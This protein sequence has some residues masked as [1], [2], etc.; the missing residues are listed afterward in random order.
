MERLRGQVENCLIDELVEWTMWHY[1]TSEPTCLLTII[2]TQ[3][4]LLVREYVI[5]DKAC[6]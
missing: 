1:A 6:S 5:C 3:I 2:V 4:S